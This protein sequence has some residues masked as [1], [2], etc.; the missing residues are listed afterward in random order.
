MIAADGRAHCARVAVAGSDPRI[1]R[2]EDFLGAIS[3]G[4]TCR[5][6]S[7]TTGTVAQCHRI[8]VTVN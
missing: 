2:D 6:V 3:G 1:T 8:S 7:T 4:D 5:F